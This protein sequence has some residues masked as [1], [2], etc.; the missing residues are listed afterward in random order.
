MSSIATDCLR[1]SGPQ[2][3]ALALKRLMDLTVAMIALVSLAPLM[4]VLVVLIYF[5]DP[6][7]IFYT[8]ER[9]GKDG[10][11]FPCFKFRTMVRNADL[12]RARLAAL[13]ERDAILFKLSNDPRV[14]RFGSYLRRYSLD[15]LPQLMN[16]VRGEMSLVGPRPPLACEVE[17][18]SPEHLVRLAVLPGL[19]GLWQVESRRSPSFANYIALDTRYVEQWSFWLDVKILLRTAGVILGGTGS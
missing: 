13:N 14:T 1:H 12:M 7:P 8:S 16:V 5:D 18:Y 2:R 17:M 9:I 4:V 6:G 11:A 15:E 10:V 19:T 3:S